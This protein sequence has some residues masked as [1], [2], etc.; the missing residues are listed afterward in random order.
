MPSPQ[1]RILA[2]VFDLDDTLYPERQYVRS[3]YR[4]VARHLAETLD[5]DQPIEGW[6]WSR[7]LDGL[8]A[9]AFEAMNEA[10]DLG[11][12]QS[13]I[14]GAVSVYRRHRPRIRPYEG[15]PALLERLGSTCRLG[16]L[17]DAFLPGGRLKLESL[18]L[19]RFFDEVLFTEALGADGEFGKPSPA[20]YEAI[21]AALDVPADRCACVADNPAKDFVAPNRLG[22]LTVQYL[23]Q[24]QIHTCKPTPV[25]GAPQVVARCPDELT[26]ALRQS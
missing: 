7:F 22:W 9:G 15:I 5:L 19:E 6:L 25:D 26:A 11:L 3:G 2:V 4:A 21:A 13:Q 17:S 16:L 12:D 24:G 18:R 10:F 8:T 20:G 23:Q 14:A 1:Q